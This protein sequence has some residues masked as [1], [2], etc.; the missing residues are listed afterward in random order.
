M[1]GRGGRARGGLV[2][3]AAKQPASGGVKPPAN[4]LAAAT[5]VSGRSPARGAAA[6][7]QQQSARGGAAAAVRG[8][9]AVRGSVQALTRGQ[10][11]SPAGRGSPGGRG[12]GSGTRASPKPSPG[13]ANN[14]VTPNAGSL[15]PK[16]GPANAAAAKAEAAALA[17]ELKS[18]PPGG[19][20]P[21]SE[22]KEGVAADRLDLKLSDFP[23]VVT[24]TPVGAVAVVPLGVA[25]VD[26][27]SQQ[28][29]ILKEETLAVVAVSTTRRRR[30]FPKLNENPDAPEVVDV[31]NMK[32]SSSIATAVV[33]TAA[34]KPR[35]E[36]AATVAVGPGSSDVISDEPIKNGGGDWVKKEE[37]N[38]TNG[39]VVVEA[40]NGYS[41]S[42]KTEDDAE[43]EDEEDAK[44]RLQP[45]LDS[46]S[47]AKTE[48]NTIIQVEA[49]EALIK[50]INMIP[51]PVWADL[52]RFDPDFSFYLDSES[53]PSLDLKCTLY[54]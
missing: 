30:V 28:Q 33:A 39:E 53:E 6:A 50:N 47:M 36:V 26:E 25:A 3:P 12:G 42:L 31:E 34:K 38:M 49:L 20:G 2:V 22:L 27:N 21:L 11:P 45:M 54:R 51:L 43:D 37:E 8:R 18:A 19:V 16:T 13:A 7:G 24:T 29:H 32:S 23:V 10:T 48:V 1:S 5:R 44:R 52:R 41:Q 14:T 9:G 35:A 40:T 15:R 4:N 46:P 17:K